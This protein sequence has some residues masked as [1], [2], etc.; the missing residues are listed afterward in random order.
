MIEFGLLICIGV[1]GLVGLY[2]LF[3]WFHWANKKGRRIEQAK[4]GNNW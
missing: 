1:G 3:L 2:L 4:K